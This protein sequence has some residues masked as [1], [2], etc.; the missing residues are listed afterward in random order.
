MLEQDRI[1]ARRGIEDTDVR[2][3]LERDEQDRNRHHGRPQNHD[4]AGRVV[5]PDEQRQAV[6]GHAGSAHGVNRDNEVQPRQDR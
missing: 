6:P 1:T 3:T 5:S 4:Q 2:Q